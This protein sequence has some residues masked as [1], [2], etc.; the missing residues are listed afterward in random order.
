MLNGQQIFEL[1]LCGNDMALKVLKE[2]CDRIA[3]G[4]YNLQ[5]YVDPEKSYWWRNKTTT[6]F[7][8]LYQYKFQKF[9]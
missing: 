6:I 4:L 3:V 2:V 5:A 7:M 9:I 1:C 8:K